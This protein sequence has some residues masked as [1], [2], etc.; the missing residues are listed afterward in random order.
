[1]NEPL[2]VYISFGIFTSLALFL[3]LGTRSRIKGLLGGY[4]KGVWAESSYY[5]Q[6]ARE[7]HYKSVMIL[8]IL[9]LLDAILIYTEITS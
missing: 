9:L 6:E 3:Y 7:A 1:M 5:M 8:G 2:W 4:G